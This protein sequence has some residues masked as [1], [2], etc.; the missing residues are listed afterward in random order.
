MSMTNL[1]LQ[2][3]LEDFGDTLPIEVI[4]QSDESDTHYQEFEVETRIIDGQ[5]ILAITVVASDG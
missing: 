4:V 3:E 5:T 1:Q 2:N